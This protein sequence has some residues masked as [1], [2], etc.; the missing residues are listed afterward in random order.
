MSIWHREGKY[1]KAL[2]QVSQKYRIAYQKAIYGLR[3]KYFP[4]STIPLVGSEIIGEGGGAR[5]T[6]ET[7]PSDMRSASACN[8]SNTSS[9]TSMGRFMGWLAAGENVDINGFAKR[10]KMS[11]GRK[12]QCSLSIGYPKRGCFEDAGIR[13]RYTI[14]EEDGAI[15]RA[16]ADGKRNEEETGAC[17]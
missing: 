12:F 11:G 4:V 2:P 14:S 5:H 6:G 7:D 3:R 16:V 15:R 17:F 8:V 10:P 1:S 13:S 9:Q